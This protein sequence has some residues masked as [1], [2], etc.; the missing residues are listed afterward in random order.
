M[1]LADNGFKDYLL[2]PVSF[3]E[4]YKPGDRESLHRQAKKLGLKLGIW[5]WYTTEYE[6]DQLASMYVNGQVLKSVYRQMKDGAL[7]I[8]PVEYWSEMEAHHLNNIYSM[9]VA[10][11]LLWDPDRDPHA[12]L[13]E[14]TNA[15]WGPTNGPVGLKAL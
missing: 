8:H 9:Y 11:Q 5:G 3:P 10:S 1:E 15:I 4:A 14:L 12:I 13:V 2:L 6:T 7:A